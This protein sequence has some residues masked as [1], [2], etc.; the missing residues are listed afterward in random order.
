M[1]GLAL[2]GSV[3][4]LYGAGGGLVIG[5]IAGLVMADSHYGAINS[6]IQTEQQKDRNLEAAIEQ[7]L[8]RQRSLEGQVAQASAPSTEN[9]PAVRPVSDASRP[10]PPLRP[11]PNLRPH[12]LPRH[13]SK[14]WK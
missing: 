3:G 12:R 9:P 11:G 5:L 7:E 10:Q 13:R 4:G 6:Q 1:E 2:G 8:E 14:T